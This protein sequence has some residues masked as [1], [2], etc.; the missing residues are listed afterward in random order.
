MF[1]KIQKVLEI[2]EGKHK[3]EIIYACESGSRA[4]GFES[5]NSDWDIRFIYKRPLAD[6]LTIYPEGPLT[7]DEN[8]SEVIKNFMKYDLDFAGWDLK[9]ALYQ[10]SKG[11]P[12]LVSW[13]RSPI[14]Y[15]KNQDG[16]KVV[17]CSLP[18]FKPISAY[19]HYV[20]MAKRNFNQYIQNI[21]GELV[22]RKKYL[23]VLRPLLNCVWIEIFNSPPPML[24]EKVY[25][26]KH[27]RPKL[28]QYGVYEE[29]LELITMKRAGE[30]LDE[31]TRMPALDKFC[32]FSLE[33]FERKATEMLK[34]EDKDFDGLDSLFKQIIL[35]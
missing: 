6:Y 30:E 22:R 35:S 5:K 17:Q 1:E 23:Y 18:F 12:D 8:S 31:M 20:H 25:K 15:K 11:N 28:E 7:L 4:W 10:L 19:Y 16:D 33:Y 29:L 3:V 26:N 24:F 2:L 9:K 34:G 13:L 32:I 27:I 21:E 14:L